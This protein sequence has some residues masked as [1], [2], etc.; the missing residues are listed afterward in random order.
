VPVAVN[1]LVRPVEILG[2]AGVTA[3]AVRVAVVIVSVALPD[4]EPDVAVMT[5][6]P[7]ETPVARPLEFTV[8]TDGVPDAQDTDAEISREVPSV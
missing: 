2:L 8:A 7:A 6:A 4:I 1:C 3:M 5:D